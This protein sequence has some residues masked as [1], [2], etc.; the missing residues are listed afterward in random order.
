MRTYNSPTGTLN[1]VGVRSGKICDSQTLCKK[2]DK[3]D[4][5]ESAKKK[6][7]KAEQ[8]NNQ[9]KIDKYTNKEKKLADHVC[10]KNWTKSSKAMESETIVRLVLKATMLRTWYCHG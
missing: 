6:R 5:L 1:A 3:C 8:A 9:K 4:K 10:L 7:K 2:C